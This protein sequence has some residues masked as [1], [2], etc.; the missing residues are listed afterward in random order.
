MF[1]FTHKKRPD[2]VQLILIIAVA[3]LALGAITPA[4]SA[5]AYDWE[6]SVAPPGSEGLAP[7]YLGLDTFDNGTSPY[8]YVS[9]QDTSPNYGAM[10][11]TTTLGQYLDN[12]DRFSNY[13]TQPFDIDESV[14]IHSGWSP[15]GPSIE[16]QD[17][18]QREAAQYLRDLGLSDNVEI[19]FLSYMSYYLYGVGNA[20]GTRLFVSSEYF[21][22]PSDFHVFVDSPVISDSDD[23]YLISVS[24]I[25][26][27]QLAGSAY[28]IA[29][30]TFT[31]GYQ[32]PLTSYPMYQGDS[33][34][35]IWDSDETFTLPVYLSD[36][37][38]PIDYYCMLS[39]PADPTATGYPF[40]WNLT[41]SGSLEYPFNTTYPPITPIP[42]PVIPV[43]IIPDPALLNDTI[44][45]TGWYQEQGFENNSITAPIYSGLRGFFTST[46]IPFYD[47]FLT[48]VGSL[49]SMITDSAGTSTDAIYD[50]VDQL[51]TYAAPMNM[52]G[53]YVV[54][55]VPDVVWVVVFAALTIGYAVLLIRISTGS[56]RDT[57][58]RFLGGR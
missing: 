42:T 40:W 24:G 45:I 44:N 35:H 46:L 25:S 15:S 20:Y 48:P 32:L 52:V 58:N 26:G 4:A 38:T 57:I 49:A 33:P 34:V 3:C 1:D 29:V 21:Y 9:I 6:F 43:D 54:L 47:F 22:I 39:F 41:T 12:S 11:Y 27:T 13:S 14:V 37:V 56:I 18:Q 7:I 17:I 55:L 36:G 31:G 50:S 10:W 16:T 2:F 8:N 19:V 30:S 51:S 23:D 28:T 53:G 5:V